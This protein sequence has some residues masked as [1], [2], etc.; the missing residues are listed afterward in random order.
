GPS[1]NS[2]GCFPPDGDLESHSEMDLLVSF[3]S[4]SC[5]ITQIKTV[6]DSNPSLRSS[7]WSL[8]V[9]PVNTWVLSGYSVFFP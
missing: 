3:G 1:E 6:L 9:L 5:C 4:L 8:H 7:A 2:Q